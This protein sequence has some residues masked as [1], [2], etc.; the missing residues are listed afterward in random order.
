MNRSG[1]DELLLDSYLRLN[2]FFI[3]GFIL[4]SCI[5]AYLRATLCRTCAARR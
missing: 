5:E 4:H 3:S 2:G 1:V